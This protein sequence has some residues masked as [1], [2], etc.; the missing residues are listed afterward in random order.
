MKR[1]I[2]LLFLAFSIL[3]VLSCAEDRT[4][5]YENKTSRAHWIIDQMKTKY[6]WADYIDEESIGWQK[7]FSSPS[8]FMK[9]LTAF[10][11]VSDSWSWCDV[12]TVENDSHQRGYFNHYDSYG[13]DFIVMTD[14]TR[15]TSRQ[16]ARVMSVVENS[17]A[18][19]CGLRR[20]DFIGYVDGVKFSSSITDKLVSGNGRTLVVSEISLND[21]ATEFIWLTER[22]VN[23]DKSE[24][25]ED[26]PFP[27]VATFHVNNK[28]V[29]YLMCN[30]LASGPYDKSENSND[31][32]NQL[33]NSVT[34]LKTSSP[35]I[36]VLDLRLCNFGTLEMANLLSSYM[37][38]ASF[39]NTVFAKT[40][41]NNTRVDEN[42]LYKYNDNAL[43]NSVAPSD[44][45]CI[46][47]NYT[48]GAA[49]W[50]I[51]ALTASLGEEHVFRIGQ[52]TAGQ[53]VLTEAIESD[54][55]TTIH[56]AVAFVENANDESVPIN[57]LVPDYEIDESVYVNLFP[58][59]N[60]N[61]VI[62][63]YIIEEI[64]KMF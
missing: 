63:S 14:P 1:I 25:V 22:N 56:P 10:A 47:S 55:L 42:K 11:P 64:N 57:G 4:Y 3:F 39:A 53:P 2:S 52:T 27:V 41:Y 28:N 33:A 35:D 44:V 18:D 6:L 15:T 16:Y 48:Q 20:G 59:G 61:E 36:M 46:T 51:N 19:R 37:L 8:D 30:S 29:G 13:M 5:E 34:Q 17:P 49:E 45:F 40:L 23:M 50:V 9:I 43:S 21:D 31:Y 58:Y 7:Y 38:D 54:Y 24:Y 26:I 60:A 32:E 12:D 62:L